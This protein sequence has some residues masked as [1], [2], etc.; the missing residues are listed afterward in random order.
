MASRLSSQHASHSS[1]P[2]HTFSSMGPAA[3]ATTSLS[4]PEQQASQQN[5]GVQ[6]LQVQSHVMCVCVCVLLPV[7]AAEMKK[8]LCECT[9]CLNVIGV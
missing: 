1:T 8:S 6:V 9:P 7:V 3:A 4:K 2:A 5:G